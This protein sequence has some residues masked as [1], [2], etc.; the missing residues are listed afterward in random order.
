LGAADVLAAARGAR[1][2]LLLDEVAAHLDRIRRKALFEALLEQGAQVWLAGAD[3]EPFESLR[4]RAR[5]YA[6][7]EGAI[8][9]LP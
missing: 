2:V 9:S 5:F 6:V 4:G 8:E 1:P 7:A 3:R